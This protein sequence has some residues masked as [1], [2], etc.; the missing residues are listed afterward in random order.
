M[1]NREKIYDERQMIER[2]KAS[3]NGYI[4]LAAAMLACFFIKD[5]FEVDFI[6]DSSAVLCCLWVSAVA[7]AVT[8]IVKDAYD[9]VYEGRNSIVVTVMGAA[10]CFM[11]AAEMVSAARGTFVFYNSAGVLVSAVSMQTVCA[12]YW[13][14]GGGT[15]NGTVQRGRRSS[16]LNFPLSKT[17]EKALDSDTAS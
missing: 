4:A 10:G 2:G 1:S 6:D 17:F 12:V 3:R 5:C 11:L 16:F 7:F 9:G 15:E 14:K 13:V 8:M